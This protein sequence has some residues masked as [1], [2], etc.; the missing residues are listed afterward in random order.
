MQ[1]PEDYNVVHIGPEYT[2]ESDKK[3]LRLAKKTRLAK[4]A[5][6]AMSATLL[7]A[8]LGFNLSF[9]GALD[10]NESKVNALIEEV[11]ALTQANFELHEQ[12]TSQ[13]AV[14]KEIQENF[15]DLGVA[16]QDGK[17]DEIASLFT[18]ILQNFSKVSEEQ[19]SANVE[20]SGEEQ[21]EA[22][23]DQTEDIL[24]IG[25]HGSLTDTLMM[26]SINT[27]KKKI[28][29]FSIPR[30]LYINGRRINQY[31]NTYGVET[32][33]GM[34]EDITG[35]TVDHYAQIDMEGFTKAI[36]LL[37]GVDITV[38]KAIYDG[39][40]PN[41]NGG[42]TAYSIEAGEHHMTGAEALKFARSRESTTDFDR[43][44]RQQKILSAVREKIAKLDSLM[45]LKELGGLFQ[46]AIS[47][48][49]TDLDILEGIGYYYDYRDYTVDTGFV[50]STSNYLYSTINESGAYTLLPKT[51]NFSEIQKV[52]R[53][54]VN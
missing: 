6:A 28:T 23:S 13:D 5:M 24:L 46:T 16:L 14:L 51:G 18:N 33:Q 17:K 49:K 9:H 29:L 3:I 47:Y 40:Y 27:E 50:L 12:V 31:Y 36:D 2:A 8:L 22:R 1:L 34:V 54:L 32:L 26:A 11:G 15:K 21:E 37:G 38:D 41:A 10:E 30:D 45:D 39:L 43:A 53:E 48:T 25:T 44:A 52:I 19:T 7:T 4:M 42:Y 20:L 35:L